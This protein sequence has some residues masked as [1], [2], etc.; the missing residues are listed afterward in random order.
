V[1]LQTLE[2][3]DL[4]SLSFFGPVLTPLPSSRRGWGPRRTASRFFLCSPLTFLLLSSLRSPCPL[5]KK[6]KAATSLRTPKAA[7][8]ALRRFHRAKC[9]QSTR[10]G[11]IPIPPQQV[12]GARG[13]YSSFRS[14]FA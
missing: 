1:M 12:S 7:R 6:K 10:I 8:N 3:E 4:S 13:Q 14:L 11:K 5:R 2:C 9:P